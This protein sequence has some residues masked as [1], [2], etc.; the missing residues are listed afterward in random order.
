M[1]KFIDA[2]DVAFTS[3]AQVGAFKGAVENL[4]NNDYHALKNYWSSSDLK[5]LHST[6][7]AHFQNEYFEYK[8]TIDD[9]RKR[10]P[11]K[12]ESN[13]TESMI[14]GSLVHTMLLTP[15]DFQKEFFVMPDLNMRT[16]E[17]KARKQELLAANP[18]KLAVTDEL[19]AQ[20]QNMKA[21]I[22]RNDEAMKLLSVGRKEAAF[23]WTCPF[24][25]LNFKAKLDQASSQ[26]W[27][28][29]KTTSEAAPDFF[30]RH[31]FNMNYDLSLYHYREAVS[32]VMGCEPPAFFIVVEQDAPYVTQV[33]KVGAGYWETGHQ[34]WLEAVTKLATGIQKDEWPG[35]FPAT[36]GIPELNPPAWAINKTL[37]VGE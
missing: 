4:E 30:A 11:K 22:E 8:T 16:N 18:G 26:H 28:E 24:S 12:R 20:A 36:A 29:I 17:G 33:Y 35:Y 10:I 21:A 27:C 19:L 14:L 6:S 1:V 25:N 7:P 31:A 9:E 15:H 37:P 23:F 34:K 5:F 13:P 32:R 3:G 2:S